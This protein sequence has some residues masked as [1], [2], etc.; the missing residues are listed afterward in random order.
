[1][2]QVLCISI[3]FLS[4]VFHGREDADLPEWPPSPLRV[5]QAL[6]AAGAARGRGRLP[7][8]FRQA[9]LWLE[10]QPP[11]LIIAPAAL[12]TPGYSLSVPNNA[13]DI[14]A[15]AWCRHNYSNSRDSN[16]ATHRTLKAVRPTFL[17]ED[18]AVHYM[19]RLQE[20]VDNELDQQT[21]ALG[22]MARSLIALG[23]GIDLATADVALLSRDQTNSKTGETW[24]PSQPDSRNG[25][26]TPR[27]GTLDQ[28]V[29]RHG[30]FV[31]RLGREGLSPLPPLSAY[32]KVEYRIA[33]S[34]RTPSFAAFALISPDASGFRTFDAVRSTSKVANML[35][36]AARRAALR[37]GWDESRI[38][39]II[40]GHGETSA[41]SKHVPV[42][43]A[44]FAWLPLPSLE[45]RGQTGVRV[46]GSVRRAL[47]CSYSQNFAAEIDWV[48]KALSGEELMERE[49]APPAALLS[50]LPANDAMVRRY[51]NAAS[52]WSTV[53]P[54]V[55]PGYDDPDH[56]RRRLNAGIA[57]D[58]QFKLL[59][60]LNNRIERLLRK[61]ILQAGFPPILAENAELE[62]RTAGFWPGT[63]LASR[64]TVPEHLASLPRLHVKINWR[65][66]ERRS[67]AVPG[68]ICIGGGRFYGLGLLATL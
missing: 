32:R 35:R 27:H 47:I 19:W 18:E 12:S 3:R 42:G 55:L 6:I 21:G 38:A 49:D 67:V 33:T 54:V 25:L 44:R 40:M 23:W 59:E 48:R 28:L 1:M 53:T 7:P 8:R 39:S 68:P 60:R 29:E 52:T 57:A 61:A 15:R 11:P 9:L 30:R 56:Y 64:Y 63:E 65:D 36:T 66:A 58:Q 10:R 20:P 31:A 14:V 5:F 62:W 43:P 45:A 17:L 50:L 4:P 51:T 2:E 46:V 16:P 37:A 26:R 41:D 22:E 34:K 13:M 24:V